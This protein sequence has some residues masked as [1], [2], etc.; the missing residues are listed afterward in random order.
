MCSKYQG[1]EIT[2][3]ILDYCATW[4][5]FMVYADKSWAWEWY[6]AINNIEKYTH[7]ESYVIK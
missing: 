4:E 2:R 5:W 6:Q 1:N 3:Q 7:L